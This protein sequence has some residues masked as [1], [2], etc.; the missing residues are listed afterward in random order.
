VVTPRADEGS[1]VHEERDVVSC[2]RR[3]KCERTVEETASRGPA[4]LGPK[5]AQQV[6]L[7]GPKPCLKVYIRSLKFNKILSP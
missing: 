6:L 2:Q 4:Q 3:R 7:W 1:S 5:P